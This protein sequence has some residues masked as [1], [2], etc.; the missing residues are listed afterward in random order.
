MS[1][2]A[3]VDVGGTSVKG[4]LIGSEGEVSG[5]LRRETRE[6]AK[7]GDLP[8]GIVEFVRKLVGTAAEDGGRRDV[9]AIGLVV[10]GFVDELRGVALSSMVLGWRDVPF[11]ELLREATG[12][13]VGFGHDVRSAAL[14]EWK[15]GAAEGRE[16]F[17]YLSLGTGVGSCFVVDGRVVTGGNGLGGEIAH[18]YVESHGP[19]CRCGK[20]GCL[21][22]VAS[23]RAISDRY[24]ALA[25]DVSEQGG[26]AEHVAERARLGE[27]LALS[28]WRRAIGALGFA[29]SCYVELL[30]P[31]SIVVGG[32]LSEAGEHLLAPLREEVSRGVSERPEL[33]GI[34]P[35]GYGAFS[36]LHGA[37]SL[38]RS[39]AV[40][41][42]LEI[43][44][45]A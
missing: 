25:P 37:A 10:P 39:V 19:P 7:D 5:F 24:T 15:T 6:I 9:E 8:L 20:Y 18:L 35:A 27:P 17:L 31:E 4:A 14:A 34:F 40:G 26:T 32:G 12:L 42:E 28:V 3:A 44:G 30:D 45:K 1:V 23:A 22:V 38:A 13:P 29:V 2:V 11:V 43:P 36:G 21:E 16:D 33:P 41:H